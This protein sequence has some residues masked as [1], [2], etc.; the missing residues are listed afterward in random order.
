MKVLWVLPR[1]SNYVE[2]LYCIV[3]FQIL[4]SALVFF[5]ANSVSLIASARFIFSTDR[6]PLFNFLIE[7]KPIFVA[8]EMVFAVLSVRILRI[9]SISAIPLSI[10]FQPPSIT[11]LIVPL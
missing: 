3:Y 9:N 10:G 11:K 1:P 2:T 4:I 5:L 8:S 6:S 7:L